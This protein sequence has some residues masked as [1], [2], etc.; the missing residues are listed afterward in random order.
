MTGSQD[1]VRAALL[2][3]DW[4]GSKESMLDKHEAAVFEAAK[5]GAQV[6]C[7]QELFYGPYFCQVQDVQYYDYTEYIPDGPTTQRFCRIAKETGMVLVLPMYEIVQPGVYYNTAAVIDAD[8]TY[9]GKYRKQHIPQTKGFWEKFYFKPGNGGYPVFDT[10]VGKV[11]VYICYD[12]HFPEGWRALGLNGAQIVF[13]PSA[14]HRG[15]SEYIWRVEQPGAAVANIYYVG[16]INRVGIEPLGENDFYGQSYFVD[17]EG[18]FVGAQGDAHKPELIVRDLDIKK[19]LEVRDRWAFY[20]D[21]RPDAYGD[22]V[23]D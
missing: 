23:K 15:L 7:F 11:G 2:Q 3:T 9:L 17:P 8:G 10:A 20:R 1:T 4:S 18:K 22:L 16:A 13:N 5:Q 19:L 12:R 14:T 21:R 6:M